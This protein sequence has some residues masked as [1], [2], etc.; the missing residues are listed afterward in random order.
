MRRSTL[1]VATPF[2]VVLGLGVLGIL[3]DEYGITDGSVVAGLG[4]GAVVVLALSGLLIARR[5]VRPAPQDVERAQAT[6]LSLRSGGIV[7]AC[8]AIG[9]SLMYALRSTPDLEAFV[10]AFVAVSFIGLAPATWLSAYR[11]RGLFDR[12]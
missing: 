12:H 5:N 11:R 7:G 9:L 4:S 6:W 1:Y 8:A 3:H 2:C 10:L